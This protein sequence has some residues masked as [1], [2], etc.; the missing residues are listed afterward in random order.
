MNQSSKKS[1]KLSQKQ[2]ENGGKLFDKEYLMN[3]IF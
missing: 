1:V 2:S 3:V